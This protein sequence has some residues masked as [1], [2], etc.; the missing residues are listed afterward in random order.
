MPLQNRVT[1][2]GRIIA[3]S[4]RGLLMGNRGGRIHDPAT[5]RLTRRRWTS[6]AWICCVTAFK[7][8]HR[9]VMGHSYTE[10]FFLDEV[11]ALAAGHRPCYE[12]RRRDARAFAVA[13]SEAHGAPEELRAPQ[14]D[15]ILHGQRVNR[16]AGDRVDLAKADLPDGVI[17]QI[18]DPDSNGEFWAIKDRHLILWSPA[19]YRRRQ[20]RQGFPPAFIVTPAGMVGALRAGYRPLWHDSATD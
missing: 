20:S 4:A 10:L 11:T 9:T 12:C 19:G 13:F 17:V 3:D 5:R 14:M 1:P 15:A 6:K 18:G 2:D 7:G 16:Q 8:R